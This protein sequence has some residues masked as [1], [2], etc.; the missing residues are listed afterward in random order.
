MSENPSNNPENAV[1]STELIARPITKPKRKVPH[2][3]GHISKSGK[4][5]LPD[6]LSDPE[7]QARVAR[8]LRRR[9]KTYADYFA[10]SWSGEYHL[11]RGLITL[12]QVLYT[13]RATH[14]GL[15]LAAFKLLISAKFYLTQKGDDYF[16]ATTI[17]KFMNRLFYRSLSIGHSVNLCKELVK[18]QYINPLR[19]DSRHKPKYVLTMKSRALF[20]EIETEFKKGFNIE[21]ILTQK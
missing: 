17:H 7:Y 20:R 8:L 6:Y 9:K 4:I 11:F 12:D 1:L 10:R 14:H 2:P 21:A 15:N 19:I 13:H 16:H 3:K 5:K 18:L